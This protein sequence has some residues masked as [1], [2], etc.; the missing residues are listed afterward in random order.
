MNLFAVVVSNQD[1]SDTPQSFTR[2]HGNPG[3]GPSTNNFSKNESRWKS[4]VSEMAM[5]MD[6]FKRWRTD[7]V[8]GSRSTSK[9][10]WPVSPHLYS[11]QVPQILPRQM[12]D[13]ALLELW[14]REIIAIAIV[15]VKNSSVDVQLLISRHM[16]SAYV[17]ISN[18]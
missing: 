6:M 17:F 13:A 12:E 8:M 16:N 4:T 1:H 10:A 2:F 9:F 18:S 7:R 15:F 5:K 3:A 11:K 14:Q